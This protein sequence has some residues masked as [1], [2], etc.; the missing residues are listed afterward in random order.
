MSDLLSPF[1]ERFITL[2]RAAALTADEHAATSPALI[3]DMFARAV[4]SGAFD[5]PPFNI[6][7]EEARRQRN[8]P[9]NW[10][11]IPIDTPAN[12]L[13]PEQRKLVPRPV[14]YF[15]A[16]RST[17]ASVMQSMGAL[18]GDADQWSAMLHDLTLTDGRAHAFAAL[19]KIPLDRY[20]AIGQRF[21]EDAYAPKQKLRVWFEDQGLP[22]PAFLK[23]DETADPTPVAQVISKFGCTRTNG[24]QQQGR[25]KKTAWPAIVEILV[26]LRA[27]RPGMQKKELAFEARRIAAEKMSE[28]DLPSVATIQRRMADIFNNVASRLH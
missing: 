5:P 23:L 16:N 2:G 27:E 26:K 28:D 7:D 8:A 17:V 15:G 1:D 4:F 21:L 10:L 14:E 24:K 25:P 13:S 22:L 9:E 12:W 18:P 3:L 6:F 19:S 11:H 20:P